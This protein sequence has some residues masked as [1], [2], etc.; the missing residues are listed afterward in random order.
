M[1]IAAVINAFSGD[2]EQVVE[3]SNAEGVTSVDPTE[4]SEKGSWRYLRRPPADGAQTASKKDEEEKKLM[5]RQKGVSRTRLA[6]G[7]KD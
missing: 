5:R 3:T 6:A 4:W 7:C 2:R 1:Q